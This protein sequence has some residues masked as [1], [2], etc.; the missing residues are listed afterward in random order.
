VNR[1]IA[2]ALVPSGVCAV[3]AA[4]TCAAPALGDPFRLVLGALGLA[5]LFMALLLAGHTL[6]GRGESEMLPEGSG[7]ALAAAAALAFIAVVLVGI[8][9]V[10]FTLGT[11]TLTGTI[12]IV[13]VLASAVPALATAAGRPTALPRTGLLSVTLVLI[14]GAA[15]VG[16]AEFTHLAPVTTPDSPFVSLSWKLPLVT[17]AAAQPGAS[18]DVLV[19]GSSTAPTAS[20]DRQP[21]SIQ[22]VSRDAQSS[23][24]RIIAAPLAGGCHQLLRVRLSGGQSLATVIADPV[25]CRP[26]QEPPS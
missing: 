15:A 17:G 22:L 18:L 4:G 5:G 9:T 1:S 2:R 7:G 19:R 24:Y 13:T 10:G 12:A 21:V 14:A 6:S 26:S 16:V 11:S 25:A 20:I 8:G 3:A 23:V